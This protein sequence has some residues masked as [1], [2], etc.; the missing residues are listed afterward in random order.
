MYEPYA[1]IPLDGKALSSKKKKGVL[2]EYAGIV[3]KG[4]AKNKRR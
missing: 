3:T 1:Y 4:R 2:D